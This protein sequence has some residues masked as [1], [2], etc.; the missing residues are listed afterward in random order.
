MERASTETKPAA[1]ERKL[2]SKCQMFYGTLSTKFMCSKCF[3]E[4]LALHPSE[5][6]AVATASSDA[7]MTD[8]SQSK[9][10]EEKKPAKPA[11]E[12]KNRCWKCNKKIG[13]MGFDCKCEYVFCSKHRHA[14]DHNCDYDHKKDDIEKLRRENPLLVAQNLNKIM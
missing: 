8:A 7:V 13:L 14:D 2:W 10:E 5:V 11:Q 1:E 4:Y 3:K 6:K 12:N 9:Q